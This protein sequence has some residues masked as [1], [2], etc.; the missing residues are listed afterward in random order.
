MGESCYHAVH[1][2]SQA[3][4][5]SEGVEEKIEPHG[6]A[7]QTIAESSVKVGNLV[8]IARRRGIHTDQKESILDGDPRRAIESLLH[9]TAA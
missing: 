3:A 2:I 7:E 6:Q 5:A 1:E 9:L 8:R 4:P